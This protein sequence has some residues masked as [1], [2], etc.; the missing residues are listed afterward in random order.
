MNLGRREKWIISVLILGWAFLPL[1]LFWFAPAFAAKH[2]GSVMIWGLLVCTAL[3]WAL[4]RQN[5]EETLANQDREMNPLGFNRRTMRENEIAGLFPPEYANAGA[6]LDGVHAPDTPPGSKEVYTRE[7]DE[8]TLWLYVLNQ[9]GGALAVGHGNVSNIAGQT[10]ACFEFSRREFPEFTLTRASVLD[11]MNQALGSGDINFPEDPE[12]SR[13][14]TLQGPNEDAIRAFFVP[15]FRAACHWS[16]DIRVG[17]RGHRL[18]IY[19][20]K[21]VMLGEATQAWVEEARGIADRILAAV[22]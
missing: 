15:R 16:K 2:T 22:S 18:F 10:Y 5:P 8:F 3:A 11:R 21:R 6:W 19:S 17:A 13:H 14:W 9:R 4:L 7:S 12:F 1:S 20:S